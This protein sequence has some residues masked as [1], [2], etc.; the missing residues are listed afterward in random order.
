[1]ARTKRKINPVRPAPF[2]AGTQKQ[3]I[4]RAAGYVRLSVEDGGRPGGDTIENQK[5][6]VK[7]YI[8]GCPDME[9]YG[10]YCEM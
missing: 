1:M 10:I 9:L 7:G 4:Y 3:H 6:L 5:G 8:E 2:A